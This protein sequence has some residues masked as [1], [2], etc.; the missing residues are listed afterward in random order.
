MFYKKI[1]KYVFTVSFLTVGLFLSGALLPVAAQTDNSGASVE[2]QYWDAIKSSANLD[3]FKSYLKE[4]PTGKY[5]AIARQKIN[6]PIGQSN[7]P[8]NSSSSANQTDVDF[9]NKWAAD[10]RVGLPETLGDFQLTDA[11]SQCPNGCQEQIDPGDG[12]ELALIFRTSRYT[13]QSDFTN[14]VISAL[15]PLLLPEYCKSD[16]VNRNIRLAVFVL[17]GNERQFNNFFIF[18]RDCSANNSSNN[19]Q[20]TSPQIN[21]TQQTDAEFLNKLAG[22]VRDGLPEWIAGFQLTNAWSRCPAGCQEKDSPTYLLLKFD[23]EAEQQYA[24][25]SDLEKDLKPALLTQYCKSDA[26]RRNI[27]LGVF[28]DNRAPNQKVNFWVEPTDCPAN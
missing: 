8:Q 2:D 6:S 16:G 7:N 4:Y 21:P 27:G 22:E 24:D 10:V 19:I 11:M 13:A 17:D 3:D 12:N 5:A 1:F 9:L 28:F 18:P 14:E 15:K 25:I 23:A 20:S 26:I